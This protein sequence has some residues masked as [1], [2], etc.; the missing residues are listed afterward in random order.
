MRENRQMRKTDREQVVV[1]SSCTASIFAAAH[2]TVKPASRHSHLSFSTDVPRFANYCG[3]CVWAWSLWIYLYDYDTTIARCEWCLSV[4]LSASIRL[5]CCNR[6]CLNVSGCFYML[7]CYCWLGF[8]MKT[9][10]IIETTPF[11][12][13]PQPHTYPL[14]W[15]IFLCTRRKN[16]PI[17]V[18]CRLHLFKMYFSI[19][20]FFHLV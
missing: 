1:V 5:L 8:A 17:Y 15:R 12:Q 7:T 11:P 20:V 14:R 19:S 13:Q 16:I 9:F 10:W 2:F 3:V 18:S 6:L 4:F